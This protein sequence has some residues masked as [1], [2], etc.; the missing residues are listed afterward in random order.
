M[1]I[2]RL[3]SMLRLFIPV[4]MLISPIWD[5]HLSGYRVAIIEFEGVPV[6]FVE[7][8]LS[9]KELAARSENLRSES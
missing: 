8:D 4:S 6:E 3:C 7:T 5:L 9:D 2:P 1:I